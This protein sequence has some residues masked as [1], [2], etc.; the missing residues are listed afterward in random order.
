MSRKCVM[1]CKEFKKLFSF[2]TEA[3]EREKWCTFLEITS[4]NNDDKLCDAHFDANCK[5][6]R[7][8]RNS[9]KSPEEKTPKR[10]EIKKSFQLEP[11]KSNFE[12]PPKRTYGQRNNSVTEK[13]KPPPQLDITMT[14]YCRCHNTEKEENRSLL[15]QV[16]EM[17]K[18]IARQSNEIKLLMSQNKISEH[19]LKTKT[20]RIAELLSGE[21][22][23]RKQL[24]SLEHIV[25]EQGRIH[26]K[27]APNASENSIAFARMV[28]AKR[29]MYTKNEVLLAQKIYSVSSRCYHFMRGFLKLN[30][31]HPSTLK[32][33]REIQAA[34]NELNI[35]SSSFD[36]TE[37][38]LE[39]NGNQIQNN[40][41]EIMEV[42][43]NNV[44]NGVIK[45]L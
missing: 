38:D 32:R 14:C 45:C 20:K 17:T 26:I 4:L 43:S 28:C 7:R 18:K 6:L 12:A 40:E 2:P 13:P 29:K 22:F 35:S 41:T 34:R 16:D 11:V 44:D 31:P 33:Q 19:L 9:P 25:A 15:N 21:K 1:G 24:E 30:L 42:D 27:A 37:H 5:T 39:S 3:S 10:P 36:E 8:K 23:L